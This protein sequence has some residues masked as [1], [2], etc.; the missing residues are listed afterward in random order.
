VLGGLA[1]LA[2]VNSPWGS[3]YEEI[4]HTHVALDVGSIHLDTDLR[5][6]INDGLMTAFFFV[7]GLEIKR[8]LVHGELSSARRALL[9]AAAALG[10]MVLPAAIYVSFN[11]G[12]DTSGWGIPMATDIAFAVGVL[13]LL[14]RR[15]PTELKVFLL[16][17]AIVDD[18]GAVIVIAVFYGSDFQP[19]ALACA[20]GVL[21]G[22]VAMNRAGVRSIGLYVLGGLALWLAVF[23]SGVHA[24]LAGVALGLLTPASSDYGIADF[25]STAQ[26]VIDDISVQIASHAEEEVRDGLAQ[27]ANLTQGTEAPLERLER[28][29]HSWV[30][31]GIV[32][33]FALA[34]AG[35]AVP[36]SGALDT[37]ASP[38][39]QGI[40]FGLVVGKP[41]G[42]AVFTWIAVRLR[43][44]EMPQGTSFSQ[45][46]AVGFLGGIGSTVSLL[47][48]GLTYDDND[49]ASVSTAK[50]AILGAS[51][52]AG[53]LGYTIIRTVSKA[54]SKA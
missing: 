33:L 19:F 25:V 8:E 23:E 38:V 4:W 42:I 12:R 5:H 37:A 11:I 41:L 51:I 43:L 15:V 14:G 22:I 49:D 3:S 52:A 9:P 21:F 53:T 16:A 26:K 29:L 27:L 32:P 31:Y 44:G 46:V 54:G 17:L 2:W 39:G 7:V 30:S 34:N 40:L 48:T 50:L 18:I 6:A 35:V 28:L 10:G 36:A 45:V 20:A 24:T 1:A 47:I 13:S